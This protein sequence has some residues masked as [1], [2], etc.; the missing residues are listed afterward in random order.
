MYPIM[1]RSGT[2]CVPAGSSPPGH[3]PANSWEFLVCRAAFLFLL[4]LVP[5]TACQRPTELSQAHAD[6]IRDSV[7]AASARFLRFSAEAQ[8]DSL[9]E[10]YSQAPG[11][12][13]L[14][15]GRVQYPSVNAIRAAL[16]SIPPGVSLATTYR[17]VEIDPLSPGVA[18]M[19][20]L[21][22]TTFRDSAGPQ[23]S[24]GGALTVLWVHEPDGWRVR[25]GH[26]SAPVARGP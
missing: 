16:E 20:A 5:V 3:C 19:S 24:F 25:G 26:A 10:M 18:L 23:A 15:N 2:T 9:A 4:I 21:F 6:A 13:F 1:R 8:W 17:D 14:E 22:E 12:R 7:R 11:F